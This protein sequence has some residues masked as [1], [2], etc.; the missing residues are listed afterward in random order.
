METLRE[1]QEAVKLLTEHDL[2]QFREWFGEFEAALWDVQIETDLRAG[3]LDRLAE[4]AT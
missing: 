1:I 4:E 2:A 3:R